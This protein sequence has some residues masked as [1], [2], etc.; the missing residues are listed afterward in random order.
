MTNQLSKHLQNIL[1][2]T[3][4]KCTLSMQCETCLSLINLI[5]ECDFIIISHIK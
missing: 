3:V 2:L 5:F 1:E 4:L